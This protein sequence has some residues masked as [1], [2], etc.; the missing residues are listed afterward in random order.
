MGGGFATKQA[1]TGKL[2]GVY[3]WKKVL[4]VGDILSFA[5]DCSV[6]IEHHVFLTWLKIHIQIYN[7][8]CYS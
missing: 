4:S 6:R 2:Y 1:Y 7:I 8:N 5:S 3:V